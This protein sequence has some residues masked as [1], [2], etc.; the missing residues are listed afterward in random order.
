MA[1]FKG[2]PE[3]WG[4]AVDVL[5]AEL[6]ALKDRKED[7]EWFAKSFS[8]T[9]MLLLCCAVRVLSTCCVLCVCDGLQAATLRPL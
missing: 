5:E 7:V 6:D 9:M 2:E 8:G 1:K 4:Q 3:K